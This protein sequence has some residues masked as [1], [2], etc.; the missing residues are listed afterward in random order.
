MIL[1]EDRLK[2]NQAQIRFKPN[3]LTIKGVKIPLGSGASEAI[4]IYSEED[5]KLPA[6]TAIVLL[7]F[8]CF[9]FARLD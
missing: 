3:L 6:R 9:F 7:F 1:G 8:F 5:V 4:A 2:K